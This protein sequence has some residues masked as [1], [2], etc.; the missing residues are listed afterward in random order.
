MENKNKY[1]CV[2]DLVQH[3]PLI[4][5]QALQK[6]A[7][8][9]ATE[10][11][12]KFDRF[13]K[14]KLSKELKKDDLEKLYLKG[15]KAFDYKVF[16]EPIKEKYEDFEEYSPLFFGNIKPKNMSDEEFERIKKR[17]KKTY[18]LK[19][20][21][22]SFKPEMIEYINKYFE[23][24]LAN[25]NF[26][27]RQSKGF[28]SFYLD[29][30]FNVSLIEANKVYSFKTKNWEEDIAVFYKFLRAGINEKGFYT[31]PLIFL[32][33]KKQEWEWD[34]RAIKEWFFSDELEKQKQK[35]RNSDVLWFESDNKYLVRDL[36]GLS[37]F[38]YWKTY[39]I[40]VTKKSVRKNEKG[41]PYYGRMKSP[42]TFK[43]I[44]DTVYFW[45][46]NHFKRILGK[47][48]LIFATGRPLKLSFPKNFDFDEMFKMIK[49]LNL[50]EIGKVKNKNKKLQDH[51]YFQKL[52][53]IL[54]DIKASL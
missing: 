23:A 44:N 15:Q 37:T 42:I 30:N 4:H 14:E 9:R 16:I 36:F 50:S 20:K 1:S 43:V 35:Y 54:E 38:Q 25:T 32:Y 34:K 19:I 11:K 6:G 21:F 53:S 22:Y 27:T 24:F 45:V 46:D 13:L 8:L 49:D 17:K 26:G 18:S 40:K 33:A 52:N 10:L 7:S 31:K 41:K 47:D 29:K 2:F 3:T 28:G 39:G 12:P 48:F 5:F 51:E